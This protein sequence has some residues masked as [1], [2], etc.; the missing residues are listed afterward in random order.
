MCGGQG[1]DFIAH[2]HRKDPLEREVHTLCPPRFL[3][4]D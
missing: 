4:G 3:N 2:A 1:F